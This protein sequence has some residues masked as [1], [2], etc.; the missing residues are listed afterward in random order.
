MS[1]AATTYYMKVSPVTYFTPTFK[2]WSFR[3]VLHPPYSPSQHLGTECVRTN[4][5]HEELGHLSFH[6]FFPDDLELDFAL[7]LGSFWA[8]LG[9]T[10]DSLQKSGPGRLLPNLC[11]SYPQFCSDLNFEI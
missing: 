3:C 2:N 9:Y 1:S 6:P 5:S 11:T 4:T 8:R 10:Q 7:I